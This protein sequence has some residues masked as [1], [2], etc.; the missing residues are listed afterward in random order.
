MTD[1]E[2]PKHS[3]DLLARLACIEPPAELDRM[4]LTRA[5]VVLEERAARQRVLAERALRQRALEED[6]EQSL[7]RKL[8]WGKPA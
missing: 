1:G 2:R 4:V 7:E 8:D 6:A 3:D 5:R